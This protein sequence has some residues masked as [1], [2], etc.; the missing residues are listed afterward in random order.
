MKIQKMILGFS[1]LAGSIAVYGR[2]KARLV[3]LFK[4]FGICHTKGCN[5]SHWLSQDFGW[6]PKYSLIPKRYRLS[7]ALVTTMCVSA[8]V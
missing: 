4:T 3:R 6:V 7:T 5:F 2:V 8:D 1:L